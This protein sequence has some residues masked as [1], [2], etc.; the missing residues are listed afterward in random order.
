MSLFLDGGRLVN[1]GLKVFS[2]YLVENTGTLAREVLNRLDALRDLHRVRSRLSGNCREAWTRLVARE[3]LLARSLH[4]DLKDPIL[5]T[6][7]RTILDVSPFDTAGGPSLRD[8][9]AVPDLGL[10]VAV[11]PLA[12]RTEGVP[13][14][15]GQAWAFTLASPACDVPAGFDRLPRS[16]EVRSRFRDLSLDCTGGCLCVEGGDDDFDGESWQLAAGLAARALLGGDSRMILETATKWIAS[17]RLAGENVRW[18]EPRNKPDVFRR[19]KSFR[20]P[21]LPSEDYARWPADLGARF[22]TH[23]NTAW[24]HVRGEGIVDGLEIQWPEGGV[25]ELHQLIGRFPGVNIATPL[26]FRHKH[27]VL[28]VSDDE[29]EAKKPAGIVK[30]VIAPLSGTDGMCFEE[31]PIDATLLTRAEHQLRKKIETPLS[32]GKIVVFNITSGNRLM[33]FAVHSVARRFPNLWLIYKEKDTEHYTRIVYEGD[34]PTTS[35]LQIPNRPACAA[36]PYA[37]LALGQQLLC[38]TAADWVNLVTRNSATTGEDS[39]ACDEIRSTAEEKPAGKTEN[40]PPR[41]FL[42]PDQV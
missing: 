20:T 30:G 38:R 35:R 31:V 42:L 34:Y 9:L 27:L 17:G 3:L 15:V 16:D 1:F 19:T 11:F 12:S 6:A 8:L 4:A 14:L 5:S 10:A 29:E 22:A 40:P 33:S 24:A 39:P 32:Q 37:G 7:P 26:L 18:V 21:I 13:A 25:D 41:H 2:T 36:A 23:L 28:W